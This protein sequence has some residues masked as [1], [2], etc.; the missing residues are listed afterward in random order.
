VLS[1]GGTDDLRVLVG[2]KEARVLA[3]S[4]RVYVVES[5]RDVKGRTTLQVRRGSEL[6]A[7]G[8]F[9]NNRP[10]GGNRWPYV[11]LL[12]VGVGIYIAVEAAQFAVDFGHFGSGGRF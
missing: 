6:L 4:P 11:I 7:E 8:K 12:V 2:D 9:S 10:S 5:P 3:A 1:P